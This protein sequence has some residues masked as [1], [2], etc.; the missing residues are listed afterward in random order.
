MQ[1]ARERKGRR[2]F[3]GRKRTGLGGERISALCI[4]AWCPGN[5]AGARP[6]IWLVQALGE[7]MA[8]RAGRSPLVAG[9]TAMV[10]RRR[11]GK[12]RRSTL[13][14]EVGTSDATL[15]PRFNPRSRSAIVAE[16]R[17]GEKG[18]LGQGLAGGPTCKRSSGCG[19]VSGLLALEIKLG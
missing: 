2:K 9:R 6:S 19:R 4:V 3:D 15:G 12:F 16:G 7:V 8:P 11:E 17:A 10:S 13:Q 14:G 1:L 5:S 18:V